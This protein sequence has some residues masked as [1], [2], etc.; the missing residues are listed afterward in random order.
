MKWVTGTAVVLRDDDPRE[1]QRWLVKARPGSA[2]NARVVRMMGTELLS[3]RI[4]LD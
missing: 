3:V 2:S 4:D 1:R